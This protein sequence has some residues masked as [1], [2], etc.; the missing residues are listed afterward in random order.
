MHGCRL[1]LYSRLLL[2]LRFLFS[3][4]RLD[5]FLGQVVGE[6]GGATLAGAA[7]G[8]P[9]IDRLVRPSGGD[10]SGLLVGLD[11]LLQRDAL[12]FEVA[13]ELV[14]RVGTVACVRHFIPEVAVVRVIA[15]CVAALRPRGHLLVRPE[16]LEAVLAAQPVVHRLHA[17]GVQTGVLLVDDLARTGIVV[18]DGRVGMHASALAVHVHGDPAHGIRC[19]LV[20]Q[21]VRIFHAPLDVVRSV[22]VQLVGRPRDAHLVAL[23]DRVRVAVLLPLAVDNEVLP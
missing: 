8:S 10:L 20:A 19:Q 1:G 7:L 21:R 23:V 15:E 14:H 11:R 22:R 13:L 16:H 4:V 5:A 2:R 18:R 17:R 6:V 9:L 12:K 3:E